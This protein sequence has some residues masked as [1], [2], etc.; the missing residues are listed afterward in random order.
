MESRGAPP[1]GVFVVPPL[2]HFPHTTLLGASG[3]PS[4]LGAL[5]LG[6]RL[7]RFRFA[8]PP[9]T[10]V[11][12]FSSKEKRHGQTHDRS[13]SMRKPN[14][15]FPTGLVLEAITRGCRYG[16]DIMDATGLPGGTVYA[17]LRRLEAA[18]CLTSR[19]EAL[20]VAET[21]GRPPRCYYRLT[22]AGHA[23]R[24]RALERFPA[25]GLSL[26]DGPSP[27]PQRA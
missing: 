21:E 5:D 11:G 18:G 26:G 4:P 15:T 12:F 10:Y 24:E 14:L 9:A 16:F 19:W 25:I 23:L 20:E 1:R 3:V 13:G 27:E 17:A 7:L 8:S 22:P 2:P 6:P